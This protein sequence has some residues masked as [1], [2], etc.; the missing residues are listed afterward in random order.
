M[1]ANAWISN[2]RLLTWP[3][4][5]QHLSSFS[6]D[7]W[8]RFIFSSCKRHAGGTRSAKLGNQLQLKKKKR[9]PGTP[10]LMSRS[11]ED[12]KSCTVAFSQGQSLLP[13]LPVLSYSNPRRHRKRR[14]FPTQCCVCVRERGSILMEQIGKTLP[15]ISCFPPLDDKNMG[16]IPDSFGQETL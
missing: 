16:L 10:F 2:T 11:H 1:S 7:M 5:S 9:R 6:L 3:A 8:M 13:V 14:E 12:P 4:G 15:P